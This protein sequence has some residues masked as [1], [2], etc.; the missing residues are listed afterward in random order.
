MTTPLYVVNGSTYIHAKEDGGYTLFPNQNDTAELTAKPP[1]GKRKHKHKEDANTK[2]GNDNVN[3]ANT[4]VDPKVLL[5]CRPGEA[6]KNNSFYFV[7]WFLHAP[8]TTT[9]KINFF[10]FICMQINVEKKY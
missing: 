4:T 3:N 8:K 6:N 2:S 1:T 10:I 9:S 5:D 7:K